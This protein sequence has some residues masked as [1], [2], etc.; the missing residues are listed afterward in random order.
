MKTSR[1]EEICEISI[2]RTP[3]RNSKEYWGSGYK[4]VS[5]SDM[6]S[7]V[8]TQTKEEITEKAVSSL[9]CK[10]I[11]AGTLLMSFKLSI[12]KLAFAGT[13]LYTNEAIASLIIRDET[14]LN[15]KFLFF[16][17]K[18]MK[19][20]GGNQAVMGVTLNSKSL[21]S[22]QIPLPPLP[23]QIAIANI[24]SRAEELIAKRKGSLALLDEY[25]KSTFLELFGDELISGKKIDLNN[26]CSKITDGTHDTPERLKE[27]VKFITGKH[28]RPFVIDY[29]NSDY[30]TQEIH[31]EIYRRCNPEF[32]DILYT[33]IGVNFGTAAMN[34]V[35]YQFSMKNVALLKPKF[36]KINPRYLEH[37]LNNE[38]QKSS[39]VSKGGSGGAQQFLSLKQIKDIKI[40]VP[41]LELQNQFAAIVEKVE[42]LK[43][44]YQKSLGELENLYGSLSQRAFRGEL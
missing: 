42:V 21:A 44:K 28:I 6:K 25:L 30:V 26:L 24:L 3:S 32:G 38:K 19:F 7:E 22:I 1:L 43:E 16:A 14:I 39:I 13:E 10:K 8:I 36:N 29:A 2:G 40:P 12:G 4:W 15:N 17:L 34:V 37:I 23:E 27:G 20:S 9:N 31:E 35:D 11:P 41:P 33:N 18:Q 5:I